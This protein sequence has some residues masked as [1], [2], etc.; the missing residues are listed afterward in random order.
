MTFWFRVMS[1]TDITVL[2][3]MSSLWT[4]CINPVE[5]ISQANGRFLSIWANKKSSVGIGAS[6]YQVCQRVWSQFGWS[7]IDLWKLGPDFSIYIY[8]CIPFISLSI[9]SYLISNFKIVFLSSASSSSHCFTNSNSSALQILRTAGFPE[10]WSQLL[11]TTGFGWD[12]HFQRLTENSASDTW[13][14]SLAGFFARKNNKP[15]YKHQQKLW[16][17]ESSKIIK[18][19]PWK[20]M[21]E[22]SWE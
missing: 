15:I 21:F 10:L 14:P 8:I 3:S 4:A 22:Q 16:V 20:I 6:A 7:S 17:T 13:L 9:L 11:G 18:K 19:N 12:Q 5:P 1:D 2:S